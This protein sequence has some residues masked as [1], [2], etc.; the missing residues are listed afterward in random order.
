MHTVC[1]GMTV[2]P[3][4]YGGV[5]RCEQFQIPVIL[6][7]SVEGSSRDPQELALVDVCIVSVV[8]CLVC[9]W[10]ACFF[11]YFRSAGADVRPH[12]PIRKRGP[13]PAL[14]TL[15]GNVHGAFKH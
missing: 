10:K 14:T 7:Y 13:W 4:L 9:W 2:R 15:G 3:N 6:E 5:L 8:D 11:G 1:I 12:P